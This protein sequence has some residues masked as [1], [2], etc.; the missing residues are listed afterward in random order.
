MFESFCSSLERGVG[1][2]TLEPSSSALDFDSAEVE[3]F[4]FYGSP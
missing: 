4:S 2:W 3:R 1:M